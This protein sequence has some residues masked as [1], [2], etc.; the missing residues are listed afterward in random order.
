MEKQLVCPFPC[1]PSIAVTV[2]PLSPGL[3]KINSTFLWLE[4]KLLQMFIITGFS[5]N[6]HIFCST[7]DRIIKQKPTERQ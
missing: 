3:L 6:T 4:L 2:Y 1:P 5:N 7:H